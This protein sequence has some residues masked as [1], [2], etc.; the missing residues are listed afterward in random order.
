MTE[1]QYTTMCN[2]INDQGLT[3]ED[4]TEVLMDKLEINFSQEELNQL[5]QQEPLPQEI[6]EV[7]IDIFGLDNLKQKWGGIH[8]MQMNMYDF[9]VRRQDDESKTKR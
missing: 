7:L 1:L 3:I 5:L 9:G 8:P 6:E 2:R 4:L